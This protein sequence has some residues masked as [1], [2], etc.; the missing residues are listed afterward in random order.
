MTFF[1]VAAILG[2]ITGTVSLGI[3]IIKSIKDKPRLTFEEEQK[4]FFPGVEADYFTSISIGMKIHNKGTKP[5]TIHH[6]KLTFNY[7]SKQM[8]LDDD[9]ISLEIPPHSTTTF[10]PS[11]NLS[12]AKLIIHGEITDCIL[13]INHTYD[14]KVLDL[15]TIKEYQKK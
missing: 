10:Y 6:T 14:T 3:A 11:L 15:G 4:H 1:E 5:T 7:N 9:T 2:A 13:T 8:E 12:R